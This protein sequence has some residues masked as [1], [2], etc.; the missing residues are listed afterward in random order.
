MKK[1][2]KPKKP[3]GFS[4]AGSVIEGTYRAQPNKD[5]DDMFFDEEDAVAGDQ[6]AP[7]NLD[8]TPEMVDMD[9]TPPLIEGSQASAYDDGFE[10]DEAVVQTPGKDGK[11]K[12]IKQ[13]AN[14]RK[15]TATNK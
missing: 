1:V 6:A 2:V 4:D 3:S 11:M 7:P 9:A 8:E 15:A 12:S 5:I 13:M 10:D 14:Q